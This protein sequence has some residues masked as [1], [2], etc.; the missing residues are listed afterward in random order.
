MKKGEGTAK[1]RRKKEEG[2]GQGGE[3]ERK[4]LTSPSGLPWLLRW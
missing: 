2:E 4:K 1:V 3:E